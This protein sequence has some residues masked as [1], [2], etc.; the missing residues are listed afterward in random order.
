MSKPAN[1][2]RFRFGKEQLLHLILFAVLLFLDQITKVWARS[3]LM[4][5]GKKM[6]LPKLLSFL[7]TENTGAVWGSFKGQTTFLLIFTIAAFCLL[8]FAYVK[9]PQ[10]KKYRPVRLL[11]TFIAAGALGNILDRLMFGYVT[12]FLNFEFIDF[13]I[14]NVAD[15]YITVSEIVLLILVFFVYKDDLEDANEDAEDEDD[16]DE[17]TSDLD[18]EDEPS[19]DET[20]AE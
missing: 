12:D 10:E 1:K 18:I 4:N 2:P 16:T 19:K 6:F 3:E 15:I 11:L 14:F 8:L 9:I 13:P 17:D 5:Q 7:Y 20:G